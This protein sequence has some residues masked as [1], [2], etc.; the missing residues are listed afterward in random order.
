[1][2]GLANSGG[3]RQLEIGQKRGI[4]IFVSVEEIKKG[5][6]SLSE[7]ELGEVAAFLSDLRREVSGRMAPDELGKLAHRLAGNKSRAESERL[8]SEIVD[9]FYSGS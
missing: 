4:V 1:L 5:I 7:A 8:T 9:G 6:E 3:A 2:A